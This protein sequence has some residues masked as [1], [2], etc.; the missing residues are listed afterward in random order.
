MRTPSPG[1][2]E[3]ADCRLGRRTLSKSRS[4]SQLLCDGKRPS[5]IVNGCTVHIVADQGVKLDIPRRQSFA[6]AK[7]AEAYGKRL[8]AERGWPIEARHGE[9]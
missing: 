7:N 4:N 9:E 8:A 3:G 1:D 2:G 5:I 6:W